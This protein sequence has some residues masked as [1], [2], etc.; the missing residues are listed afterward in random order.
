LYRSGV[1]GIAGVVIMV[2]SNLGAS[3][4]CLGTLEEIRHEFNSYRKMLKFA[5]VNAENIT[6]HREAFFETFK[7]QFFDVILVS[8]TFLKPSLT[9]TAYH[10]NNYSMVRHDRE[11]KEGGGVAMYIRNSLNYK[12]I[13]TS[14]K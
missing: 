7:G 12:V 6:V 5:H 4:G 9:N 14:T 10:I 1:K 8:E 11:G 13:A 3:S 2:G